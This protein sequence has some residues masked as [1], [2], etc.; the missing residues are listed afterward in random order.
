MDQEQPDK[1]KTSGAAAGNGRETTVPEDARVRP[2]DDD[3]RPGQ[4]EGRPVLSLML[5]ITLAV[6][7]FIAVQSMGGIVPQVV[8]IGLSML[9]LAGLIA[10]F[11]ALAGFVHFGRTPRQ[12]AFF[13]K[14]LDSVGEPC[15]VSDSRGAIIYSNDPYQRLVS[16]AGHARLVNLETSQPPS[17]IVQRAQPVSSTPSNGRPV[18]EARRNR[19]SSGRTLCRPSSRLTVR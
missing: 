14:L 10:L 18:R 4:S 3:L 1:H 9:S 13:D 15:V 11:G 12:K 6:V 2:A 5:A 17:R 19:S 8:T 7:V 16:D